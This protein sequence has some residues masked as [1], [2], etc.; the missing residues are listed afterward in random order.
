MVK[1]AKIKVQGKRIVSFL[2]VFMMLFS[3]VPFAVFADGSKDYTV[4]EK[5]TR[6]VYLHAQGEDPQSTP[7]VSTVYLGDDFNVYFAID[8]PNKGDLD[9]EEHL[10]PHYDLNGYT[11]KIYYDPEFLELTEAGI[12]SKD[13][14]IDYTIPDSQIPTTDKKDDEDIGDDSATDVP[15]AVGYFPYS[16]GAGEATVEGKK[17]HT[18]YITVF[19]SGAYVPQ[20][21]DGKLWYN[22]C[23]LPVSPLK[24]G[25]T[26]VFL[27][28]GT[29]DEHTLE[30]FA[31]NTTDDYAQTF[32]FTAENGG[33]HFI[34][35]KDKLKP[36]PPVADPVA[37]SYTEA[38]Q[39]VLDAEDD[40]DIYYSID[41]GASYHPYTAPIDVERSTVIYAYAERLSDGKKSNT[42]S[43]EYKIVPKPPFL[44]DE[45]EKLIPNVYTEDQVFNVL[46]SDKE[47]FDN[48][49]DDNDVYYTFSNLG[50]DELDSLNAS[51]DPDD[52]DNEWVKVDKRL[53]EI[54]IDG[55]TTVRLVTVKHSVLGDEYSDISWYYLGIKPNPVTADPESGIYDEV[56][57][58]TL[59]TE[60]ENAKIYYTTNGSDP[61]NGGIL[62]TIPLTLNKD[63]TVRAAAFYD[64]QW[65]DLSSFWYVFQI[66][67]DY[68][69]DAFYPSGVYE[70]SVNVTLTPNTPENDIIYSTDGGKTWQPYEDTITLEEDT[71]I[72]AKAVDK[73]GNEGG[74]YKFTYTIKPLPPE[75]AP[76]ST[77]FTNADS[78]SIH[79]IERTNDNYERYDLYYTLDG[80]DPITSDTRILADEEADNAII[81]INKYTVVTAA[82]LRDGTTW[83]DV[84]QHSYDIVVSKP[85]KPLTTLLPGY[86]TR[87]IGSEPF[88]TQFVPVPTGTTIYYTISYGNKIEPD[89][90]PG[91]DG[92]YEYTPGDEIDIKG[93]TIIKAV[94]VNSFGAKSDIGIFE[95][96]ITPEAPVAAPSAVVG[97]DKLP[98]VP[99]ET[100]EGSNVT[101]TVENFENVIEDAPEKF[102]ID[103]STGNA[104]A[105]EDCTE[106]LGEYSNNKT[107]DESAM[108]EIG[109]ELDN[110][111]SEKNVYFY[112]A[113]GDDKTLAPPFADKKTGTYEEINVDG[114]NNFLIV[115]LDSLNE[116]DTIQYMTDNSG[117]WEEYDGNGLALN[118]DTVLQIRSV[119]DEAV[120][121]VASYVYEFIPLP[122]II[123]LPSGRYSA[124][125]IPSTFIEYDDRVPTNASYYIYFRA[126][127]ETTDALY[128]GDERFINK[129]MF[130]KA[131]V[132]NRITGKKSKNAIT[133][134][135]VEQVNAQEGNVYTA[136]PYEVNPGDTKYI[137]THKLDD[138]DYNEGIKLYT[139]NK[140]ADIRYYYT[141][142][143][144]D[145]ISVTS[146][147]FTY[148]NGTPIIVNSSMKD[149]KITA[150]LIDKDGNYIDNT[151]SKFN[152]VFVDLDI[153]ETSLHKADEDKTEYEKNTEYTI[154]DD[155]D[156]DNTV[157]YYTLNGSDPTDKDN[158]TRQLYNGETLKITGATVV[159][160]VYYRSC[161]KCGE[162]KDDNH[163]YCTN[164]V[165]GEVGTYRYTVPKAPVI[166]V[167][168]DR[169]GGTVTVD[170]TRKYTKDIFGNEHPTH[171][172]YIKGYPDGSVQ[173][174][175]NITRE[176]IAVILYRVMNHEYEEPFKS[177]GEVF[178]DVEYG[179]WSVTEIEY[180]TEKGVIN[181]YPDGSFM[182]T[183]KLTRAEFAALIYRF[184]PEE[185]KDEPAKD[186]FGDIE[187]CWAYNE[188]LA[189]CGSGLMQGYEDSSFR[190]QNYI[191][192]AE[193]M[194]VMNK[195][196]GR[197][198]D[199]TYVKSLNFN[200]F[201]DLKSEKWYYVTVL[202]A[203]ITHNYYLNKAETVEEKWEDWK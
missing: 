79:C 101:Y 64:G 196:L 5:S 72:L 66:V 152:Y 104:Y 133:Y 20:K 110:I 137:P 58:I 166:V 34:T 164:A 111:E 39:V 100:V 99:V 67:D 189:I 157:I 179:R 136:Y 140:N 108:L 81:S 154:I 15:I 138:K 103:M 96:V 202:E 4:E 53:P 73:N 135:I 85:V 194:T 68:G 190:P 114:N 128:R 186:T 178:P 187:D 74:E 184:V 146:E 124:E 60:T 198:P 89:P 177:T 172:G 131:Y 78:M 162:C 141:F 18:A 199:E 129:T 113:D 22:L 142:T 200:P 165:Y 122:P 33:H 109:A 121:P 90:I 51:T 84:V 171:I 149:I 115:R 10:E 119:K 21:K 83:S 191:T 106:P 46:V 195:I 56:Q 47:D 59:E 75:F 31:K 125:P 105:D 197:K 112:G 173:A 23:A 80:S 9:G 44:F 203:T 57:H 126:N 183:G 16:N 86:Y 168:P 45:N 76:E 3:L 102:Y 163:L 145:G 188:I 26:E 153:P 87:E 61:R 201:N 175:G 98:V 43:F 77:Q 82:V 63:T 185:W 107:Y 158:D 2:L 8:D 97:S 151:E 28:I 70:G 50:I 156:D 161:G 17:Y 147:T 32:E 7:I 52:A 180:L 27:E 95:Y 29:D 1:M 116:G 143:R 11:V 150:W 93:K 92:T 40:C 174:D 30:L 71:E 159:R 170:K 55:Q 155:Y 12:S 65:S 120:S 42:V 181:G 14:P 117:V 144:S 134:Y 54:E 19:F 182:P 35:I 36:S 13:Y 193:V 169:G 132:Y 49:A 41:D 48:I 38:Q 192:R 62:Y 139:N 6:N 24:T 148:D 130:F 37:G 88:T 160:T 118:Q 176:E 94:A 91:E 69:V 123:T 167:E 25:N 127:G